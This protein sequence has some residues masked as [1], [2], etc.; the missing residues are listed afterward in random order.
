M[1]YCSFEVLEHVTSFQVRRDP[2]EPK[3][4]E[5]I[6]TFSPNDHLNDDSLTLRKKFNNLGTPN[7]E[8]KVTSSKVKI[9]WK[10]GKDLTK[11]VKGAPPSFFTWF[12]FENEDEDDQDFDCAEIA[13]QLA[14][15][16]YP[17]AHKIFQDLIDEEG[18]ELDEDEDL[19]ENGMII[20]IV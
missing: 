2:N 19:E 11:H 15:E 5:F 1:R 17:H 4:V 13:E 16:I 12:D 10:P 8:S 7:S 9:N 18:D 6:F 20:E 14:D 3:D